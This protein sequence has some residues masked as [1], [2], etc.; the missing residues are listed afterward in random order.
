ME[1]DCFRTYL[2]GSFWNNHSWDSRIR[3]AFSDQGQNE[4]M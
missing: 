3:N 1:I 4:N 2:L